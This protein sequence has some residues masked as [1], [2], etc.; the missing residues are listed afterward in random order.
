MARPTKLKYVGRTEPI[1]DEKGKQTGERP[2]DFHNGV[3]ARHLKEEDLAL[4]SDDDIKLALSGPNPL[5]VDP[6]AEKAKRERER[7]KVA[8]QNAENVMARE[9]KASKAPPANEPT[10]DPNPETPEPQPADELPAEGA[11][12]DGG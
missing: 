4:L 7:A 10:L 2:V 9:R 11:S 8:K 5:Y 1:F 3:P 12:G 6:E